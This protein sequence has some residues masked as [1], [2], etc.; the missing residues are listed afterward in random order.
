MIRKPAV[1]DQHLPDHRDP[2]RSRARRHRRGR[3]EIKAEHEGAGG[4]ADD[5]PLPH[6]ELR[7]QAKL[8][9]V[10]RARDAVLGIGDH[11]RRQRQAADVERHHRVRIHPRRQ[12]FDQAREQQRDHAGNAEGEPAAAGQKAAQQ[13]VLVARAVFRN[14]LLRRRRDAEI[15]H[16][17]EQ[18][19][20]GPDIDIDAI[21]GA[22]HPAREQHLRKIGQ[23]CADD[24]DDEDGA[25][26]PPRDRGLVRATQH[27]AQARDHAGR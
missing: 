9:P 13:R 7:H 8:H 10:M 17:A 27:A 4:E 6:D 24:A 21:V 19:H 15:H 5:Q 23:A 2:D 3:A 11:E 12:Q 18:Q 26:E 14:Q 16:A 25:G 1:Q 22:A 20:P